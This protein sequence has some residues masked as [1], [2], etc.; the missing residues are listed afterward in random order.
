M[1]YCMVPRY[2]RRSS[3]GTS[4]PPGSIKTGP[5]TAEN[6]YCC[7]KL[8]RGVCVFL[9]ALYPGTFDLEVTD[10]GVLLCT[11]LCWTVCHIL[12]IGLWS[13]PQRYPSLPFQSLV[14]TQHADNYQPI[15]LTSCLCK[16][17]ERIVKER[18]IWY[19]ETEGLLTEVHSG[20]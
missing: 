5:Y 10:R 14:T 19:L 6:Y 1:G 8:N 20:L 11:P 16:T 17:F 9:K 12:F 13:E 4:V 15:A 18:L 2:P 7:R 3:T